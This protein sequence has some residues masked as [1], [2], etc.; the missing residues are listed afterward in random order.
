MGGAGE[1]GRPEGSASRVR[2]QEAVLGAWVLGIQVSKGFVA[3]AVG[4]GA[5]EAPG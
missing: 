5:A 3:T 4:A 1:W 2:T